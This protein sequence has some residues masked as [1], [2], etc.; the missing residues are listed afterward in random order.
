MVVHSAR[1]V[2]GP[3]VHWLRS[4]GDHFYAFRTGFDQDQDAKPI[5]LK[6][7]Q[8]RSVA[9]FIFFKRDHDRN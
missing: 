8:T 7:F 2:A 1:T 6:K 3:L 4:V 9:R 5:A